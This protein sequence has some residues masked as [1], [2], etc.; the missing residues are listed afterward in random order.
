MSVKGRNILFCIMMTLV[1]GC[2]SAPAKDSGETVSSDPAMETQIK[3]IDR[4]SELLADLNARLYQVENSPSPEDPIA[5]K[6]QENDIKGMKLRKQMLSLFLDHCRVAKKLIAEAQNKP[7]EKARIQEEWN[8]HQQE[9]LA[10]LDELDQK[11]DMLERNRVGLE[12]QL[13]QQSLD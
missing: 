7:G 13:I 10:K 11:E 4:L 6:I 9:L 3:N 8:R 12:M 1:L 5:A 2:A